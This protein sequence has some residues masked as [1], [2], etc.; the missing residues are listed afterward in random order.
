M[1]QPRLWDQ[2]LDV[3]RS[4]PRD[5]ERVLIHRDYHPG[6]VL[7]RSGRVSGV[8]DWQAAS[9]GPPSVDIAWCRLNVIGRFGREAADRLVTRWEDRSRRRYHPW[10]EVVL[11]VD[12][13]GSMLISRPQER[14]DLESVLARRL[15]ELG[16]S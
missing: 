4:P 3:F 9:V 10:A 7:W 14:D 2:A 16:P 12:V 5:P 13:M 6:N 1:R 15:S 8:V 11:L